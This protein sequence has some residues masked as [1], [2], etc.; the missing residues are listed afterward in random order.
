MTSLVENAD[1]I[2]KDYMKLKEVMTKDTLDETTLVSRP[3]KL[4][5]E[6]FEEIWA[7][8]IA[9]ETPKSGTPPVNLLGSIAEYKRKFKQAATGIAG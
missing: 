6:Q 4:T 2:L 9:L 1:E 5:D 8:F 7:S 3:F